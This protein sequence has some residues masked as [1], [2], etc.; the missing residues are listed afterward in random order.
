M[1]FL[2]DF[3][4]YFNFFLVVVFLFPLSIFCIFQENKEKGAE[5]SFLPE[6]FEIIGTYINNLKSNQI[7]NLFRYIIFFCFINLKV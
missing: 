7:Y 6:N 2:I 3:P 5:Y 4:E 1:F